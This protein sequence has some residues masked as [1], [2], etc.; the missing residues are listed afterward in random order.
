V[1]VRHPSAVGRPAAPLRLYGRR[2]VLRPLVPADFDQWSEVRRRNHEWLTRWEPRRHPSHPDPTS[3]RAAFTARCTARDRDRAADQGYPFGVFVEQRLAGEVNLNNVI[4]G[5][6]QSATIGYWI[7]EARAGRRYVAESVAVV[8]RFAFEQLHLHRLE[9]CIVPRNT[10]SRRVMEVLR[11]RCE[12]LAERFLEIDGVWED[13][14]RFAITAEEFEER[15]S[16]LAAAW[17]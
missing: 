5:A 15:R 3:D 4:R 16:E 13:H 12:G 17:F 2:V 8:A 1:S 14:L 10:N 7:D 9:I 11:I 6:M